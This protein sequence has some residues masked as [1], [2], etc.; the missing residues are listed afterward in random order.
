MKTKSISPDVMYRLLV[1]KDLLE[2]LSSLPTAN[3]DRYTI[4]QHVLTAHDASE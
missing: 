3:P 2:K 1:A 4:A